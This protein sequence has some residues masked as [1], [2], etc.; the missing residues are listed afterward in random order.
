MNYTLST[1]VYSNQANVS[2]EITLEKSLECGN[3]KK[4]SNFVL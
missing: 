4:M 1:L 3:Y 2:F